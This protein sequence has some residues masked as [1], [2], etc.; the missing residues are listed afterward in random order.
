MKRP[1]KFGIMD[2]MANLS[3]RSAPGAQHLPQGT[4]LT[5]SLLALVSVAIW[6][7]WIV[8]TRQ[9]VTVDL[10]IGWVGML[11]FGVPALVLLPWWWR[12]GLLPRGVDW[13]LVALMVI[14]SGAPFLV[15]VALGMRFAEAAE[16]GVLLPGT[17]PVFVALL[18]ALV[19]GERFT[20][21]RLVGLAAAVA[22]LIAIGGPALL[23]GQGI[24]FLLIPT[25]AFVWAIYTLA[26]R[27]ANVDPVVAAGII[28]AWSTILLLP[29][30]IVQS[31]SELFR[32][33]PAVFAGQVLSQSVLS[34]VVA[35][36]CYGAA[37]RML[38]SSRA[39]IFSALVPALAALIAV[40]W[41]GE[42]PTAL[43]VAG[44]VLAVVGVALGSGAVGFGRRAG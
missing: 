20:A 25:G 21:S 39:A 24:G 19:D 27:R 13:R 35:L 18:S 15:I 23:T 40:P 26:F 11:R 31:P 17:M 43:T 2:P 41:L 37:V 42:I 38:G 9:A 4:I 5:G 7:V 10:P 44:I 28:A 6:A 14:G 3:L 8:G 32:A 16:I 33:G 12:V 30:A 36:V 34:G 29:L 1:G 22:A